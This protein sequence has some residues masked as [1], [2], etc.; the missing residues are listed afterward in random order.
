MSSGPSPFTWR[1]DVF[2]SFR[3]EDT[4]S[5]F[6][7]HLYREL[8]CAGYTTFKDD[9]E[10]Q[11]GMNIS[12]KIQNS[13]RESRVSVI[14]ISKHYG[15]S[16]W[17]LDELLEILE[18]ERKFQQRVIP[19]FYEVDPCEVRYQKRCF[20]EAFK[21]HNRILKAEFRALRSKGNMEEAEMYGSA[22]ADQIRKWKGALR[23]VAEKSGYCSKTCCEESEMIQNIVEDVG[24]AL[25]LE[26]E[27]NP[28]NSGEINCYKEDIK[29][30]LKLTSASK[31]VRMVGIW[32]KE[33]V[34]K[35]T[36]ARA[37]YVETKV[38]F[39]WHCFI[40]EVGK[41]S[42]VRNTSGL[43]EYLLAKTFQ[44]EERITNDDACAIKNR[45]QSKKVLIVLD[46]IDHK[47]QLDAL[48]KDVN[49]FGPGS[50]IIITTRDRKLLTRHGVKHIKGMPERKLG[51]FF[52]KGPLRRMK[53]LAYFCELRYFAGTFVEC[54]PCW[55]F[56]R[57]DRIRVATCVGMY[58]NH[59]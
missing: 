26:P 2:V 1:Y 16:K 6:V 17:C 54:L 42:T 4:R 37:V 22:K 45:L 38:H 47:N 24:K 57:K 39:D 3:G 12:Q 55:K 14:V 31:K 18:C 27:T 52:I 28:V 33:G 48:A 44:Q 35:T 15:H 40:D 25:N 41:I 9:K 21:K 8:K 53:N 23:Q 56:L 19:V 36:L 51:E 58:Q 20:K 30:L 10:L 43:Q 11:A 50:R 5:N 49:W 13:I 7:S 34:G 29:K 46:G 59:R 32:G